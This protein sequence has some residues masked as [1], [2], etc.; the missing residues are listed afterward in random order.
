MR[1]RGGG[2]RRGDRAWVLRWGERPRHIVE[3]AKKY[4]SDT[5]P[6]DFAILSVPCPKCGGVIKETYKKFQCQGCDFSLWK[7]VASRQY[8]IPEVEE[9]LTKKVVGPLNDFRSKM[10]RPFS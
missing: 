4:E 5:V 9:L 6:G 8:E 10:G 3:K 7:I 1:R 2:G